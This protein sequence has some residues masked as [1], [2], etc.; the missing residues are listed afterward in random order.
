MA[1]QRVFMARLER[2]VAAQLQVI[3][4]MREHKQCCQIFQFR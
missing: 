3:V 4:T 2:A 1:D